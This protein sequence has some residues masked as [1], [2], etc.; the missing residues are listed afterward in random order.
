MAQDPGPDE[1]SNSH[2][3]DLVDL[4]G[5]TVSSEVEADMIRGILEANGI[6][7]MVV[8]A[9]ELPALGYSVKVPRGRVTEAEQIVRE[10]SANGSAAV[11]E[12]ES[13]TET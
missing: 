3:L 1:V 6:S 9:P 5:S 7:A 12:A 13:E 4:P 10:A 11:A 8:T 2:A